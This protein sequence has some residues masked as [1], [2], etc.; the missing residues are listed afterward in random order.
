MAEKNK[1][2]YGDVKNESGKNTPK[3]QTQK[4]RAEID[5]NNLHAKQKEII[6]AVWAYVFIMQYLS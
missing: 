5:C 6:P 4:S 3:P 2:T 1:N